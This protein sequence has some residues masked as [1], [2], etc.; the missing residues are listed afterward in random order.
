M[1]DAQAEKA[2]ASS[3]GII[4]NLALFYAKHSKVVKGLRATASTV[5]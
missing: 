4:E 2:K 5:A 1:V 3:L